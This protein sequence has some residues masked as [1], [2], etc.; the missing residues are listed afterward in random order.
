MTKKFVLYALAI[1]ALTVSGCSKDKGNET[2]NENENENIETPA[3]GTIK[4]GRWDV[5]IGDKLEY[6]LVFDEKQVDQY[7]FMEG[8]RIKGTYTYEDNRLTLYAVTWYNAP[9]NYNEMEQYGWINPETLEPYNEGDWAIMDDGTKEF[10]ET[11]FDWWLDREFILDSATTAHGKGGEDD[12]V[13]KYRA[14]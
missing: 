4:L 5:Y 3:D 8:Q 2:E 7:V 13:Y 14:E 11:N 12:L 10:L 9:G 6:A 1:L